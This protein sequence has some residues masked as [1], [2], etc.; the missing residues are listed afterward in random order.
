[1][2]T[3]TLIQTYICKYKYKYVYYYTQIKRTGS[4]GYGYKTQYKLIVFKKNKVTHIYI[5]INN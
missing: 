3:N 2:N 4:Y 5:Y 1:M